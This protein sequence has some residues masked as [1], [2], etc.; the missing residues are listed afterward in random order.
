MRLDYLLDLSN[1]CAK[2]LY[3]TI[4]INAKEKRRRSTSSVFE[5]LGFPRIR[6]PFLNRYARDVRMDWGV[7]CWVIPEHEPSNSLYGQ[8]QGLDTGLWAKIR[9]RR[10][11]Q[12]KTTKP[13]SFVKRYVSPRIRR[14]DISF[15]PL[16]HVIV[17]V[18]STASTRKATVCATIDRFDFGVAH[19]GAI[20]LLRTCTWRRHRC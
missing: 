6:P 10:L 17:T 13:K 1:T 12:S 7:T 20:V 3:F 14:V 11:K 15:L 4:M 19:E 9:S 18:F 8:Y 2:E 5:E 16:R